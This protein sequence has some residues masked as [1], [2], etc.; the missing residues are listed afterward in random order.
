[1]GSKRRSSKPISPS[2]QSMIDTDTGLETCS[3][4]KY[5]E[6]E[7]MKSGFVAVL[8][9]GATLLVAALL[10]GQSSAQTGTLKNAIGMEF[11]KIPAGEFMMGCSPGDNACKNDE[12]PQHQV[13]ISRAFEMGKYEVTQAQWKAVMN[14]NQS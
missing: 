11:V 5:S 14:A 10:T 12:K 8:A 2:R 13:R 3:T 9:V 1:S 4:A 7:P 6:E